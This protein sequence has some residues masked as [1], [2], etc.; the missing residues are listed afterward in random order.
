MALRYPD[1]ESI[2]DLYEESIYSMYNMTPGQIRGAKGALGENIV[3]A[4]VRLASHEIGGETNRFDV[5]K[6]TR[7]ITINEDYVQNLMSD[8]L[9]NHIH[10]NKGRYIY[11]IEFDRAV[12]IDNDFILGIE[13]KSYIDNAM[14]KRTLKDF[15]LVVK[16]LYPELLF[17]IFQ[18]ENGLGGDYGKV[19]KPEHLGSE[20]THT[21]LSHTPTV[22]LEIIT[23]LDGN[24][25]S[26][27]EIHKRQYFKKLLEEN[28]G[29]CVSKF[30]AMLEI[31]I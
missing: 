24:R 16:L 14:F 17:C 25:K 29:V 13:C 27:R 20:S 21:L 26:N 10:E 11:K 9:R 18:L 8:V 7:E 3:D 15:E 1:Y 31:F 5:R 30:R 2:V 19:S 12:E 6:R 4:I 28:V 23:L 22:H